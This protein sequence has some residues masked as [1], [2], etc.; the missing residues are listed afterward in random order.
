MEN[1]FVTYRFKPNTIDNLNL[2]I[3]YLQ[4]WKARMQQ[5]EDTELCLV[6]EVKKAS[7][8]IGI[9]KLNPN[10]TYKSNEQYNVITED[11]IHFEGVLDIFNEQNQWERIYPPRKE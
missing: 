5:D 8:N 11:F 7:I 10:E 4:K 1:Y 2:V 6:C 3:E 9:A